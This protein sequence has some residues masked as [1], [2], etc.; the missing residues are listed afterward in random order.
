MPVTLFEEMGMNLHHDALVLVA[1][2]QKYLLLRNSGDFR[3]PVLKVEASAERS[4]APTRDL[5]SDQPGRAFSSASGTPSAMEQTDWHQ[6]AEDRFAAEAAGLLA[7]RAGG[8]DG[9]E[10]VIVAPPRTLAELRRHYSR[11]VSARIVA[12]ID[13]DLTG[14][15]VDE[16][17]AIII[18]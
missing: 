3:N 11:E 18:R 12:E 13:K 15:P 10:I 4:G 14:H 8:D 9:A 17:T 7:R 2:G 5:G 16:I 1:D 6:Q